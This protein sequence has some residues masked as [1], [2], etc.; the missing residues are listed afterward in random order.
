MKGFNRII[1][2][3]FFKVPFVKLTRNEKSV[4]ERIVCK[5]GQPCCPARDVGAGQKDAFCGVR[6]LKG[7]STQ[8]Y[9]AHLREELGWYGLEC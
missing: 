5:V 3:V 9:L 6:A 2:N 7:T 1:R 4:V 8:L